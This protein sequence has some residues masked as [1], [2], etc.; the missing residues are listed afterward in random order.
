MKP[1]APALS[2]EVLARRF[3]LHIALALVA[4][5]CCSDDLAIVPSLSYQRILV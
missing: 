4:S 2:F 1:Q 5:A 3:S